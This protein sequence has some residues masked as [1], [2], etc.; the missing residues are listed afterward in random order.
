LFDEPGKPWS[1]FSARY[2]Q[3]RAMQIENDLD[4]IKDTVN[5][6]ELGQE[7]TLK[8]SSDGT[9]EVTVKTGDMLGHRKLKLDALKFRVAKMGWRDYGVKPGSEGAGVQSDGIKIEGGLPDDE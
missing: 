7:R 1:G 6:I 9:R 2:A 5:E 8:V 3:A 4:E